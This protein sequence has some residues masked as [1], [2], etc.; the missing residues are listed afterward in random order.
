MT[1]SVNWIA[2]YNYLFVALN[3]ENRVL[4]VSGARFCCM[5][6]QIDPDSPSY[7]QLLPVR[8][9]QGQSR[10]RKDFY[11]DHI[12]GLSEPQRFSLHRPFVDHVEAHD[13]VQAD[14]IRDI[15]LGGGRAVP[16]MIILVDLWNLEKLNNSLTDIDRATFATGSRHCDLQLS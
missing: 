11:W 10:S 15:V 3:S 6:Q 16:V 8:Q 2:A 1:S 9:S 4:C 12:Q 14:A 5:M 13:K 7:Q